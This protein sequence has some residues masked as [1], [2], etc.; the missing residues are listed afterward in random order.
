MAFI[1]ASYYPRSVAQTEEAVIAVYLN[2]P[3]LQNCTHIFV[4]GKVLTK[5][6]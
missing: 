2:Q 1:V 6:S 5:R 4:G 3:L